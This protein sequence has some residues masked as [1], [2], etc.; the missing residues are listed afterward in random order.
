MN[1]EVEAQLYV[2]AAAGGGHNHQVCGGR[3]Q[4]GMCVS[5][6]G[7]A[8]M[9]PA[10]LEDRDVDIGDETREPRPARSMYQHDA[11]RLGEC[12]IGSGDPQIDLPVPL[13]LAPGGGDAGEL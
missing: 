5:P 10:G 11:P 4:I 8:G 9:D 6:V 7:E 1:P 3:H 2:R 12:S 13:E